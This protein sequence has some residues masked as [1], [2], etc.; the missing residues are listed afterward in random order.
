MADA[1]MKSGKLLLVDGKLATS[2]N[3]CCNVE[4]TCYIDYECSDCGDACS[5]YN[6]PSVTLVYRKKGDRQDS[7]VTV[8]EGGASVDI[9]KYLVKKFEI[10]DSGNDDYYTASLYKKSTTGSDPG[11][12]RYQ[13]NVTRKYVVIGIDYYVYLSYAAGCPPLSS[14]IPQTIDAMVGDS[15]S[16]YVYGR[17]Y[18]FRLSLD[19][20][21]HDPNTLHYHGCHVMCAWWFA[22]HGGLR[23][24]NVCLGTSGLLGRCDDAVISLTGH[25]S[26]SCYC[27]S[28]THHGTGSHRPSNP[29]V[30][31]S[32]AQ[33]CLFR[34]ERVYSKYLVTMSCAC[35]PK[36]VYL[37]DEEDSNDQMIDTSGIP[38]YYGSATFE[39][40]LGSAVCDPVVS[41]AD[42]VNEHVWWELRRGDPAKNCYSVSKPPQE[43][44]RSIA[45]VSYEPVL[46]RDAESPSLTLMLD[47]DCPDGPFSKIYGTIDGGKVEFRFSG[48]ESKPPPWTYSCFLDRDHGTDDEYVCGAAGP[49]IGIDVESAEGFDGDT[50]DRQDL[51]SM[52][53]D[54]DNIAVDCSEGVDGCVATLR[55]ITRPEDMYTVV[56][57]FYTNATSIPD[58]LLMA[59]FVLKDGTVLAEVT[60]GSTVKRL[61]YGCGYL[62]DDIDV[63]RSKILIR[64]DDDP[65]HSWAFSRAGITEFGEVQDFD[66]DPHWF[67]GARFVDEDGACHIVI[68]PFIVTY[69]RVHVPLDEDCD[70][71][72]FVG[73]EV[74]DR[75]VSSGRFRPLKRDKSESY[76]QGQFVD[77]GGVLYI[78]IKS[79]DGETAEF[80]EVGPYLYVSYKSDGYSAYVDFPKFMME[81]YG[82]W[83]S[84][85]VLLGSVGFTLSLDRVVMDDW[86]HLTY[87]YKLTRPKNTISANPLFRNGDVAKLITRDVCSDTSNDA[88]LLP[89]GSGLPGGGGQNAGG[90]AGGNPAQAGAGGG[91]PGGPMP[92]GGGGG[93]GGP[94]PKFP[95]VGGFQFIGWMSKNA[96]PLEPGPDTDGSGWPLS[97]PPIYLNG[98]DSYYVLEGMWACE[99]KVSVEIVCPVAPMALKRLPKTIYAVT[100]GLVEFDDATDSFKDVGY[101]ELEL[102][103]GGS[104]YE[105]IGLIKRPSW[106]LDAGTEPL[107]D[108]IDHGM[109][110]TIEPQCN[111]ESL[112]PVFDFKY[113]LFDGPDRR[114]PLYYYGDGRFELNAKV[115]TLVSVLDVVFHPRFY[116]RH[117]ETVE[118]DLIG[119]G[120]SA[121]FDSNFGE[122]DVDTVIDAVSLRPTN[123]GAGFGQ[124]VSMSTTVQ[125]EDPVNPYYSPESAASSCISVLEEELR[126]HLEYISDPANREN[127]DFASRSARASQLRDIIR[128]LGSQLDEYTQYK[129]E[130]PELDS[131]E[132][133]LVNSQHFAYPSS[134]DLVRK[135][136]LAGNPILGDIGVSVDVIGYNPDKIV[137]PD[138]DKEDIARGRLK[139]AAD[140]LRSEAMEALEAGDTEKFSRL[141]SEVTRLEEARRTYT[142]P[143]SEKDREKMRNERRFYAFPGS[144]DSSESG[145]SDP[146]PESEFY[147]PSLVKS[148]HH[149][150]A[151][152][153]LDG[154]SLQGSG[155]Q[156][157]SSV[158]SLYRLLSGED[159]HS[160]AYARFSRIKDT[161]MSYTTES[162]YDGFL[163]GLDREMEELP[164][165]N[166]R[167][168][169]E[170][171][172]YEELEREKEDVISAFR[173]H[174]FDGEAPFDRTVSTR[175]GSP[176]DVEWLDDNI[177]LIGFHDDS[178]TTVSFALD[179]GD[180]DGDD[181]GEDDSSESI[182]CEYREV[183][184][185]VSGGRY[186]VGDMVSWNGAVWKCVVRGMH[187]SVS[188]EYFE[189]VGS[190]SSDTIV[191]EGHDERCDSPILVFDG[192]GE[193]KS[194]SKG[195]LVL[196]D[197]V[198]WE[199]SVD[200][201]TYVFSPEYF[202]P[203]GAAE[204]YESVVKESHG[205]YP[206]VPSPFSA[207]TSYASGDVVSY[208]GYA[209]EC[210]EPGTFEEFSPAA[211][212]LV[213]RLEED[214]CLDPVLHV[215]TGAY[216][217]FPCRHGLMDINRT[218]HSGVSDHI[219]DL[220]RPRPVSVVM[221]AG[222]TGDGESE[223]DEED[224]EYG[225]SDAPVRI[226]ASGSHD[227][228][229]ELSSVVVIG[230][231][232]LRDVMRSVGSIIGSIS[233]EDL[234]WYR[235]DAF[236]SYGGQGSAMSSDDGNGSSSGG[237][238]ASS[239]PSILPHE[240]MALLYSWSPI[241]FSIS[242]EY[243]SHGPVVDQQAFEA[244]ASSQP[245]SY[246]AEDFVSYGSGYIIPIGIHGIRLSDPPL[247]SPPGGARWK[248]VLYGA[249]QGGSHGD[250]ICDDRN[251]IPP[252]V[253][254]DLLVVVDYSEKQYA[255]AFSSYGMYT[256]DIPAGYNEGDDF[257]LPEPEPVCAW[258][259]KFLGWYLDPSFTI[260]ISSISPDMRGDITLYAKM[261]PARYSV[262]HI[263]RRMPGVVPE[264]DVVTVEEEGEYGSMTSVSPVFDQ[265]H[266]QS[267]YSVEAVNNVPIQCTDSK[268]SVVYAEKSY[269]VTWSATPLQG[270][271]WVGHSSDT[272]YQYYGVGDTLTVPESPPMNREGKAFL[273]WDP[274]PS[275]GSVVDGPMS[276][277]AVWDDT[278]SVYFMDGSSLVYSLHGV[279]KGSRL[280]SIPDFSMQD[281][282]SRVLH[283]G[284]VVPES[285]PAMITVFIGWS[286]SAS[287]GSDPSLDSSTLLVGDSD[288]TLYAV[289]REVRAVFSFDG[290][291]YADYS[292]DLVSRMRE[293]LDAADTVYPFIEG[294]VIGRLE[295]GGT[296]YSIGGRTAF[297]PWRRDSGR[298]T[299]YRQ[300]YDRY[301]T[302]GGASWGDTP[303]GERVPRIDE[304]TG[305]VI[306]VEDDERAYLSLL[307]KG[308]GLH[309]IGE[310]DD[311]GTEPGG[312]MV[313]PIYD[314]WTGSTVV[315]ARSYFESS[316]PIP[317][318]QTVGADP[319]TGEEGMPEWASS[320]VSRGVIS[321]KNSVSARVSGT[322][323]FHDLDEET[324]FRPYLFNATSGTLYYIPDTED[325]R[326]YIPPGPL[327]SWSMYNWFYLGIYTTNSPSYRIF[328][329]SPEN[330]FPGGGAD[331]QG[332]VFP[333]SFDLKCYYYGPSGTVSY[334]WSTTPELHFSLESSPEPI[335]MRHL[336][337]MRPRL[338]MLCDLYVDSISDGCMRIDFPMTL[339]M[340]GHSIG[341]RGFSSTAS[342]TA[343]SLSCAVAIRSDGVKIRNGSISSSG[344]AAMLLD[345]GAS[346]RLVLENV[347][348]SGSS[349][350]VSVVS[351]ILDASYCVFVGDS[352]LSTINSCRMVARDVNYFSVRNPMFENEYEYIQK[353]TAMEG[354]RGMIG[355]VPR[356]KAVYMY[357]GTM[358]NQ[359]SDM[360]FFVDFPTMIEKY[361]EYVRAS[362]HR[363]MHV[364][365][366]MYS[367][368]YLYGQY[369]GTGVWASVGY[370][371]YYTLRAG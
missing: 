272:V 81:S 45:I 191:E 160:S 39:I 14:S 132:A 38:T 174:S 133:V 294:S 117:S 187:R 52:G 214:K 186:D 61:C 141:M 113:L 189:K 158:L 30:T 254:G 340:G 176:D 344:A 305:F 238:V 215:F 154:D 205:R 328:F 80:E 222:D 110:M 359:F 225:I 107:D 289:Y 95:R 209:W 336:E 146:I 181:G 313:R 88:P 96:D 28:Y 207:T 295:E 240:C 164:P 66:P 7:T 221:A 111:E 326:T 356:S 183:A 208:E 54:L 185:F 165:F 138:K 212:R 236:S 299:L 370:L 288:L 330:N 298:I 327:N 57:T 338:D 59:R 263:Y 73:L 224:K 15:M 112:G 77:Q 321:L 6:K 297:L 235:T 267:M 13:V 148:I 167:T 76:S 184:G 10:Q 64:G 369:H 90:G 60:P 250:P 262:E 22:N 89:G 168:P 87:E 12:C 300:A 316:L 129:K 337:D 325:T 287:G 216:N 301:R 162:D 11:E 131:V 292:S 323:V 312:S 251:G 156:L 20:E 226:H 219:A 332:S 18:C 171:R 271:Y 308:D 68:S 280:S 72:V 260:P 246:T 273:G 252:S 195:T 149:P 343:D 350:S 153:N 333:D 98:G 293:Y 334:N 268:A 307:R 234:L 277:S 346:G 309:D 303:Y 84:N 51:A 278:V 144:N 43:Y 3:C 211:F 244:W 46:F 320:L 136:I 102:P 106:V 58:N 99:V 140:R 318:V 157:V 170:Q 242:Y 159:P 204:S 233:S 32:L 105:G 232:F 199:C 342:G 118:T 363:A 115:S 237:S 91:R 276:F 310:I 122:E 126:G 109:S 142:L 116:G 196:H 314:E 360:E 361:E 128:D 143:D 65:S 94:I 198:V 2:E 9:G 218:P 324:A 44:D 285:D 145:G 134:S 291:Y 249:S 283:D 210:V 182:D 150:S 296:E 42:P 229:Y 367:T 339:D 93:G 166:E 8:G 275:A 50:Y 41:C 139:D 345:A 355:A 100:D 365:A 347:G 302:D 103:D 253:R 19:T 200:C 125:S 69:Y 173:G 317:P 124:Q 311:F 239:V 279:S 92:G 258:S 259:P 151:D 82:V 315:D 34:G 16:G 31:V 37:V 357:S 175:L 101:I 104:S 85:A 213:G 257:P 266:P 241:E 36:S 281:P 127:P 1:Y 362:S 75:R 83:E 354:Y 194:F 282:S 71:G 322:D 371:L 108:P 264:V 190:A 180:G 97:M 33:G 86:E 352:S 78:C 169:E 206:A 4:K 290:R 137:I 270:G 26:E 243:R 74:N 47:Q 353:Q 358:G 319:E 29:T 274:V 120:H 21:Y 192:D 161:Y 135:S 230:G 179:T 366:S 202:S 269:T 121:P 130:H 40:P 114:F 203:I 163:E 63:S 119:L 220:A 62:A 286:Y 188:P 17:E 351:G 123:W 172:R 227:P 147:Y 35:E 56:L 177:G 231:D 201:D 49:D 255:I 261:G 24:F 27:P 48:D 331:V 152:Q 178:L 70:K 248:F 368:E 348:V 306:R 349:S 245:S 364:P 335:R 284:E 197:G 79:G 155:E 23:K 341:S 265:S 217:W 67:G 304:F 25:S 329:T 228:G 55:K 223:E 5:R 193:A 256:R 247:P 53:Y